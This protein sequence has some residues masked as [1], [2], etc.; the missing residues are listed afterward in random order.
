MFLVAFGES[1]NL[2]LVMSF[3]YKYMNVLS[4]DSII[5]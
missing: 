5:L 2:L 3:C 1:Y 4:I